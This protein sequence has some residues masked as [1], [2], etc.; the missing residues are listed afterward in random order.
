MALAGWRS[1]SSGGASTRNLRSIS[2]PA[3][4]ELAAVRGRGAGALAR[5]RRDAARDPR[6]LDDAVEVGEVIRGE[7][8]LAPPGEQRTGEGIAAADRGGGLDGGSRDRA[9]GGRRDHDGAVAAPGEDA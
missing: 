9:R 5:L 2:M 6:A 3:S 1:R 8:V 4:S 7:A